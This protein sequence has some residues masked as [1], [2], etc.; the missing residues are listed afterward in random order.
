M[1]ETLKPFAFCCAEAGGDPSTCD[2]VNKNHGSALFKSVCSI[3]NCRNQAPADE[4]FCATH[5]N[6]RKEPH[7]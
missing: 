3:P 1:S 2:C 7:S 5:R 4:A 6:T